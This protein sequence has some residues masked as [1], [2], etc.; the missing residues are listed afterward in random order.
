[1]DMIQQEWQ[2][3]I[4]SETPSMQR[5]LLHQEWL[6]KQHKEVRESIQKKKGKEEEKLVIG[7]DD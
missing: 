5:S 4:D 6:K 3:G 1:M 2:T 7:F